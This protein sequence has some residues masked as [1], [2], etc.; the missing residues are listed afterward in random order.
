MLLAEAVDAALE[1]GAAADDLTSSRW[2]ARACSRRDALRTLPWPA[3]E[4]RTARG[5]RA[6][7]GFE[8]PSRRTTGLPPGAAA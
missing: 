1:R 3:L 7:D 4:A 5:A 2:P 8:V 6:R